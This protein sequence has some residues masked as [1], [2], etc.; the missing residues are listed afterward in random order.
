MRNLF[1][2][3]RS[4]LGLEWTYRNTAIQTAA[5]S[6]IPPDDLVPPPPADMAILYDLAMK[7]ELPNLRQRALQIA[8]MDERYGPFATLLCQLVERYDED[9]ILAL[10]EHYRETTGN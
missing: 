2:L 8:K 3:L 6:E 1:A 7:G 10:I 5:K 9:K 4:H